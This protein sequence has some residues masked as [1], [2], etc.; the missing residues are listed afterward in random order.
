MK[1]AGL[2]FGVFALVLMGA[3]MVI[4]ALNMQEDYPDAQEPIVFEHDPKLRQMIEEAQLRRQ[5]EV[6]KIEFEYLTMAAL[7]F[8]F[9]AF[10][11]GKARRAGK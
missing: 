7:E 4:S 10:L 2:W 5:H 8:S 6:Y 11:A 9:A 3:V 1:R